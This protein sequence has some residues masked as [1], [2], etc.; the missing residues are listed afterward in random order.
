MR[1]TLYATSVTPREI[2]E[3]YRS[4]PPRN[5]LEV[6]EEH[7]RRQLKLPLGVSGEM[8]GDDAPWVGP[9]GVGRREGLGVGHVE[10][11]AEERAGGM[12][13]GGEEVVCERG[14]GGWRWQRRGYGAWVSEGRR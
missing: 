9:E 11:G 5:L 2:H 14:G 3:V 1:T 12:G 10:G 4:L 8:R 7:V 13:E 6:M